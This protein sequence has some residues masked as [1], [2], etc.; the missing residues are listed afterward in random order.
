MSGVFQTGVGG[1]VLVGFW[2]SVPLE[3]PLKQGLEF[4][5]ENRREFN[6]SGSF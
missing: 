4:N 6:D 3:M 1:D 5:D 2:I